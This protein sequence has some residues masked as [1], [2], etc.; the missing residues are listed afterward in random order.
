LDSE[1]TALKAWNTEIDA[2]ANHEYVVALD[3]KKLKEGSWQDG[4]RYIG[5]L[6]DSWNHLNP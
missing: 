3:V 2:R 5:D 6:I 1:T 4:Q